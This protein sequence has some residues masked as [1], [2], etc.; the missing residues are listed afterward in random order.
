MAFFTKGLAADNMVL[1]QNEK[2]CIFGEAPASST[3]KMTFRG[4]EYTAKSNKNNQWTIEFNPG[5]PCTSEKMTLSCSAEGEKEIVFKDVA[6]GEVWVNSGQ[7]NAQLF[8]DRLRFTYP[9]EFEQPENTNIRQIIIPVTFTFDGERDSINNPQWKKAAPDTLGPMSGTAY[10]FAKKLQKELNVPVGIINASQGG[11][12]IT[13]WMN[14]KSFK[15]IGQYEKR[16]AQLRQPGYVSGEQEKNRLNGEKWRDELYQKDEGIQ[17]KWETLDFGTVSS[18]SNWTNVTIPGYVN[19][20]EKAGVVWFKK[21]I[22]LTAAEAEK[23][24]SDGGRI[25]MGTLRDADTV[26]INGVNVGSTGY[27]YPPRRYAVNK[28]ILREGKNTITVRVQQNGPWSKIFFWEEK[29]YCLTS[30]KIRVSPTACR[31]LEEIETSDVKDLNNIQYRSDEKG[32]VIP[33]HGEW[34]AR[35]SCELE[36]GQGGCFFEYEP[37]A[38]FNAML[39]PCFKTAVRGAIWYQGESNAGL[40]QEY[41]KL[42]SNM[43]KLWRKKFTYCPQKKM[44]FVCIQLP[45]WGNVDRPCSNPVFSDWA[46]LRETQVEGTKKLANTAVSVMIDAGEWNDLHPEKKKTAGYRA[47]EQALRIA[48]GKPLLAPAYLDSVVKSEAGYKVYIAAEAELKAYEVINPENG[49]AD[50]SK[51]AS[52]VYGFAVLTRDEKCV[53]C[54]AELTDEYVYVKLP[55]GVAFENVK[56]LRYLWA[57]C[58]ECV[59]L[60]TEKLPVMPGRF[61]FK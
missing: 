57:N 51:P 60:Y 47:A 31:N 43:I 2:N 35:K 41:T 24:N 16:L 7:S 23:F 11:T 15:G 54:D 9:E 33:L 21:E 30:G 37:E 39:A 3:V 4:S 13:A 6:V 19:L 59:N 40:W 61:V 36:P 58:P 8:M 1:L 14:A 5:N 48:Y 22:E 56:E 20:V 18:D 55:E 28:D 44:P 17:N 12:P 10:F 50:F 42:L 49:K 27:L 46:L 29:P 26:Y 25:W 52:K 53:S 38:Q 45:S 34:K 32:V